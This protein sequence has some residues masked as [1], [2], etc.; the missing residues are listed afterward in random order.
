[1][2]I[3]ELGM[4]QCTYLLPTSVNDASVSIFSHKLSENCPQILMDEN[5]LMIHIETCNSKDDP[6]KGNP[7]LFLIPCKI[8]DDEIGINGFNNCWIKLDE[9]VDPNVVY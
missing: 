4:W 2:P 5:W 9:V 7:S 3:Y 1:M 8:I 6:T